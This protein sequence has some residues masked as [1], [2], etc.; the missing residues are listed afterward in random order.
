MNSNKSTKQS[1]PGQGKSKGAKKRRAAKEFAASMRLNPLKG[2]GPAQSSAGIGCDMVG[3]S[4]AM[5]RPNTYIRSRTPTRPGASARFEGCDFVG[6]V[7]ATT[8]AT[9]NVYEI[10]AQSSTTFPRLS[11]IAAVYELYRFNSFKATLIGI[12]P[13]TLGG[14]MTGVFVY[15]AG[16]STIMTSTQ[17]RNEEGQVTRKF[18]ENVEIHGNAQRATRPWFN[19]ATQDNFVDYIQA[20]FHLFTDLISAATNVV[21]LFMSYDVEFAQGQASGA[22]EL[23][24]LAPFLRKKGASDVVCEMLEKSGIKLPKVRVGP[25]VYAVTDTEDAEVIQ[26]R[27]RLVSLAGGEKTLKTAAL[28][29][30]QVETPESDKWTRR[31]HERMAELRKETN[32][33]ILRNILSELDLIQ[34]NLPAGVVVQ[35]S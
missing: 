6:A 3:N 13:S 15:D 28:P 2:R 19:I 30:Q 10:E 27:A 34:E 14:A 8:V 24:R 20:Q 29:L 16:A 12:A 26:L 31:W 35:Q 32:P 7:Q 9:D 23:G 21:E 11:A 1:P 22:P 25:R 17:V 18:W 4:N 5:V 33:A